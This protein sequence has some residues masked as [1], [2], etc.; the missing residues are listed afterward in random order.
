MVAVERVIV[1][2]SDAMPT[3]EDIAFDSSYVIMAIENVAVDVTG[4]TVY[5]RSKQYWLKNHTL[6]MAVE[7]VTV[8]KSSF[9]WTFESK[10]VDISYV[11]ITLENVTVDKS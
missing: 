9:I 11:M 5:G 2:M 1:N 6:V 10:T 8:D 3:D 7:N 4:Y